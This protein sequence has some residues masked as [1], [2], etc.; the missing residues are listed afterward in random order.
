MKA[1]E[2]KMLEFLK[3]SPQFVIPIYQRTYSWSQ[4]ECRQLWEDILRTGRNEAV[5]AHFVG[6]IVYVERGL[7]SIT[8]PSDLL[9][10]DGQQRLTTVTLLIEALARSLGDGEPLDGFSAKKLRNYYLLNPLEDGERKY[11]LLLSQTDKD[12]LIAVLEQQP[13]PK[14]HSIRVEANF[15]F[16]KDR[17]AE[18]TGE[19]DALCKGLA[20]LVIVDISLDREQDNPQLIFESLNS[21]GRELSQADLIRNFILM[22]L[23]PRLQTKLYERYWR[24]MEVDFGQEAYATHFDSF[25]RHYLT[26]KTGDIPNLR[27]IYEAFKHYA[28]SSK[29]KDFEALVADIRAFAGYYCAMALGAEP[30]AALKAAFQDIRE[31]KVEVAFPFLLELYHDY[32]TGILTKTELLQA[33]RWVE[34]YVFR[35]AV[36]GIPTNSMNKTFTTFGRALKKDRYLESIQAH[37]LLLPSYRRFPSD[38]EFK[39]DIQLKDLYNFRSRSY[40]L[41]RLEN[42]D[43]KER[44]PVDEYTIEHVLPQNENLSAQWQTELG[45]EWQRIQQTYLHTLGNLT[46]TGYNSEYS[47]RPFAEKRDMKGG[48][49]ESPLRMNQGLGKLKH[50]N[51]EAIR[52]RAETLAAKAVS[53]WTAPKLDSAI[54]EAYKPKAATTG[55]GIDDHPYLVAG[56]MHEL[57]Q[58]FRKQVLALDACVTEEFLKLYVAYKAE[59]N[60]VDVV[61]QA[62]RLRLSLNMTF[63]EINDPKGLCKDVS[64]V[65]RWGN[66]DIE[67]GLTSLKSVRKK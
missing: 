32:A 51:E 58:A 4:K 9:V 16:F 27:E 3:K 36:C 47:D 60:F 28:R 24:P 48:F 44:V 37:F 19:L 38:D 10:I 41:R 21:T 50:W 5:S 2:A 26:V 20:K 22:G 62:K 29:L 11:K 57:F 67:I 18:A 56:P 6:S 14:E 23:E 33:A 59:T 53:V 1:T 45:S 65:G 49:A 55:Y 15:E 52:Q 39:R 7:Y 17:V 43:R 31:L 63:P 54:L 61:P 25:M 8:S 35:R 66:G 30:D 64:G 12:S 42:H 46:L 13:K 34:S 40:W